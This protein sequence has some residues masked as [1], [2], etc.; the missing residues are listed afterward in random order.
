MDPELMGRYQNALNRLPEEVRSKLKINSAFRDPNDPEIQ[1]MYQE[2]LAGPRTKPMADPRLSKHG[3][4]KA[5]DTQLGNLNSEERELVSNAFRRS[6]LRAPVRSEGFGDSHTHIELD[7]NYQG[8]PAGPIF[9]DRLQKEVESRRLSRT[10]T[11][12]ANTTTVANTVSQV[13]QNDQ[14]PP[15]FAYG[16]EMQ[17]DATQLT[18][19]PLDKRDNM[20]VMDEQ[21][22]V[23]FTMNDSERVTLK[24]GKAK[25]ET[26]EKVK[27]EEIAPIQS[28]MQEREI[29]R[30]QQ[31][32]N[33]QETSQNPSNFI[34]SPPE[35]NNMPNMAREIS[36]TTDD[37]F[38]SPSFQRA[39]L[40]RQFL[41]DESAIGGDHFTP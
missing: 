22:K 34:L 37:V 23:Q 11:Q 1:R 17:T 6:G 16:G 26:E 21:G 9:R 40:E 31:E 19:V 29:E 20:A 18:A 39:M 2:W 4:G 15:A 7:P 10:Q 32:V 33:R 38:K 30:S 5:F 24:D 41:K 28:S 36:T 25:I 27:S 14:I 12:Q 13:Q 3:R 8:E 35:N